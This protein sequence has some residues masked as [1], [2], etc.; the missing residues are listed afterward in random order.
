MGKDAA[1]QRAPFLSG[2]LDVMV[3]SSV[4]S[5]FH[6]VKENIESSRNDADSPGRGE[7]EE[8]ACENIGLVEPLPMPLALSTHL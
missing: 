8:S 1:C 3:G 7:A 2:V 6:G 5:V 4:L